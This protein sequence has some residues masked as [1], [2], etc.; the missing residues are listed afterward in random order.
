MSDAE[1]RYNAGGS[2]A[3]AFDYSRNELVSF[4]MMARG[5]SLFYSFGKVDLVR[6]EFG[7]RH[8]ERD[9]GCLRAKG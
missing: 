1:T 4:E 2:A 3:A 8:G 6:E 5:D 7:L 9:D